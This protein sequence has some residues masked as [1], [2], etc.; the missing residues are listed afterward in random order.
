[1]SINPT[2]IGGGLRILQVLE[3][4]GG[5]S[6]RHFLDLCRGLKERGHHVEAVYSPVRAE[7]A[8]VRELKSLDLP[9]VHAVAMKRSPGP[10]DIAA[11]RALRG[12]INRALP[13]HIVHGH[14]SKAG[15]LTRFRLPGRHA[16]R[17]YTPHAFRTMDPTLGKAGRLVF[18]TI[19]TILAK[20]FTDHLVCVS[21][22]EYAHARSLGVPERKLSVI[23]NGVAPPLPD[24]AK[25]VRASFGIPMDAFVFGFVGRLSP[26]KAPERLIEAFRNAASRLPGAQL[27][28]VG[29]GELEPKIR[30]AIAESGLQKR[31]RLTSAFTG[32]QAVAAFDVLVMPSRYEAMSYVMLEAAAAGKPIVSTDVGGASTAI[33]KDRSGLIVPNDGDIA[34]LANAMVESADP[35]RYRH[36]SA[37]AQERMSDFSMEQMIDKT[38]A[39]Y[40]RL[41]ARP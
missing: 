39:L 25:T 29:A 28:M 41:V 36:L 18:G 13:F 15:A 4:S 21:E 11:F 10:S 2:D 12:I 8:F 31:I 1:M 20:M 37:A 35:E 7:D 3:P 17:V 6:G 24:M 26:Q 34:K 14:S 16:P 27:I 19:E 23:V 5:G 38:E 33:D 22:D 30:S 40:R 9:A 32:P